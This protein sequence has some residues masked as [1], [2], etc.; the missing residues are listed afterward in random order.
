MNVMNI[1]TGKEMWCIVKIK[2][3]IWYEFKIKT[4][5]EICNEVKMKNIFL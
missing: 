4:D 3:E 2:K 1:K 5:E